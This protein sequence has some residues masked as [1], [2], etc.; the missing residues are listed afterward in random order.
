MTMVTR[1]AV[2]TLVLLAFA[3]TAHTEDKTL[4]VELPVGTLPY[5]VG[6]NG[7]IV[8]GSYTRPDG[9]YW[10]PTTGEIFIGGGVG[11]FAVSRDGR[12]I[13]GTAVDSRRVEQAAIWQRGTEWR[14]LGSI[15]PNAVPCGELLSTSHGA[16]ADGK[17]IVG[18]AW[19]NCSVARAFR[20]E[21]ATGMVDL[22]TV[23]ANRSTSANGVSGDGRVVVGYQQRSDGVRQAA[24]WVNGKEEVFTGPKGGHVGDAFGTNRNGSII[25]GQNCLPAD[26]DLLD[27]SAWMW[28]AAEGVVC[29]P[30]PGR[31]QSAEGLITSTS[32]D[33]R[34]MGGGH[35]QGLDSEAVI[36]IDR[37]PAY[38]KDYLRAHGVPRA[39]ERWI[40]T[41]FVNAVSPDG[42]VLVGFGAG[43]RDFQGFL[44]ILGSDRD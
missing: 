37:K 24:R 18:L 31:R 32:D 39:F 44:V 3:L 14:L 7:S 16:S 10:M 43:P 36:W 1:L 30:V 6:A 26:S 23:V 11:A 12:T 9:F 28:T 29:M 4:L 34:V 13:A 15:R 8:V 20:W 17:V 19:D 25:V 40:N 42:R 33:G 22:G 2:V 38:L 35:G 5:G 41:G 27:Q 21:E